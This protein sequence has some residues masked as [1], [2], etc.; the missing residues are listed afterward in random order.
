MLRWLVNL[1]RW[2]SKDQEVVDWI[3]QQKKA[4]KKAYPPTHTTPHDLKL[5]L[6]VLDGSK[7][8]GRKR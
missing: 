2:R 7:Q 6:Y 5:T 1:L 8:K 3:K 4:E